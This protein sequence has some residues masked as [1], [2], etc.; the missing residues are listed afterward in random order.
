MKFLR[1]LRSVFCCPGCPKCKACTKCH[2]EWGM[3]ERWGITY[4]S[5][6][7]K[8]CGLEERRDP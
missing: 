6:L 1:W 7:C 5:R 3:W 4:Q 2:H 8:L